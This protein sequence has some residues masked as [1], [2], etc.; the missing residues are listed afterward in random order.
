[1][2][3]KDDGQTWE[4][5]RV[6]AG[7]PEDDYGYPGLTFVKDL[8]VIVYHQRDGLHV[9]RIGIPWFYGH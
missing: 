4:N 1:V 9:A 7:D 3:S 2:L 8:A 5:E 6:I